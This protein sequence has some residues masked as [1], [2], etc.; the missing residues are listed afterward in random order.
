MDSNKGQRPAEQ[1]KRLGADFVHSVGSALGHVI[2]SKP[3]MQ[4]TMEE[5]DGRRVGGWRL[6][7]VTAP[8]PQRLVRQQARRRR[9]SVDRGAGHALRGGTV[10]PA[11]V[12][13]ALPVSRRPAIRSDLARHRCGARDVL[14]RAAAAR[15]ADH[16][17]HRRTAAQAVR[18]A[19]GR[20]GNRSHPLPF[21]PCSMATC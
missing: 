11:E 1:V 21:P 16:T 9:Q 18:L 5:V 7:P 20:A 14:D 15:R 3:L 6:S 10:C 13:R 12:L 2:T 4:S 19:N 8:P 17:A